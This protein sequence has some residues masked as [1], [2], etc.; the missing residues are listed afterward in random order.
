MDLFSRKAAAETCCPNVRG[1]ARTPNEAQHLE[2]E[3]EEDR[4]KTSAVNLKVK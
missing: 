2:Y 3:I 4:G 1:R